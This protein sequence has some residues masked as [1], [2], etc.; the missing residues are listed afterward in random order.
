MRKLMPAHTVEIELAVLE[1][2]DWEMQRV[3]EHLRIIRNTVL[4]QLL[5][6]YNQMTRTK[7][8]KRTIKKYHA[9]CKLIEKA[10]EPA[11][12]QKLKEE[13][14]ELNEKIISCTMVLLKR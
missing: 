11:E 5:K 1:L 8:Y 12:L 10:K 3:G 14:E 7:E 9:L 13:K 4:G 6:N 2:Q